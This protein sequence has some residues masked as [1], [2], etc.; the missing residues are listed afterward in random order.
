M[1]PLSDLRGYRNRKGSLGIG[2]AT[3]QQ[4][5]KKSATDYDF[6]WQTPAGSGDMLKSVYDSDGDGIVDNAEKV[7]NHTVRGR[8]ASWCKIYRHSL[9]PS[10]RD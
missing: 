4:L 8:C 6:E 2:G 7:N 9:Y 10:N 5:T 1:I 3:G